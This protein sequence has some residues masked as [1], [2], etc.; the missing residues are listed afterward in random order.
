MLYLYLYLNLNR[1]RN[2]K[3]CAKRVEKRIVRSSK[4]LYSIHGSNLFMMTPCETGRML[5]TFCLPAV[6]KDWIRFLY[7]PLQGWY[8]APPFSIHH[9]SSSVQ[10]PHPNAWLSVKDLFCAANVSKTYVLH[11]TQ[12]YVCNTHLELCGPN[13]KCPSICHS[14]LGTR[15]SALGAPPKAHNTSGILQSPSYPVILT[16][17]N[18]YQPNPSH[19]IPSSRHVSVDYGPRRLKISIK[20]RKML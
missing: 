2:L 6:L 9:P 10:H 20:L 19:S 11:S 15:H 12:I 3:L 4:I 14:P 7:Q 13:S 18:P 1:Y 17:T 8:I 5:Y 16:H